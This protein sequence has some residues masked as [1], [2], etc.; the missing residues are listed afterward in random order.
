MPN[1]NAVVTSVIRLDPPLD[2]P[3][4]ELLR[5]ESGLSVELEGD[6]RVRLDPNDPRSAGFAQV[7]DGLSKQGLP[8]YIEVDP[9]TS[10]ITLLLIPHVARVYGISP[11]GDDV[12]SVE[13]ELSH[14]RHTLPGSSPDFDELEGQL[15]EALSTGDPVILTETDDHEIIDIREYRPGPDGPR[16]PFPKPE[17]IPEPS[18]PLRLIRRIWRIIL[19]PWWCFRCMSMTRAQQI[20]DAMNA[21]SCDPL[22]VPAPCIPFMYPDDG[23]WGRAHE[24]ARLMINMGENPKK[25]WIQGG[26]QVSTRNKPNCVVNWGWHVAPTLC[27]RGPGFFQNQDMV[28][29]PSLFTTPVSKATW[30]G[31]QGDPSATLTDSA[32]SIFY[33]WGNQ[34]DPTYTQTNT[35]LANYRLQLLNRSIQHGPPPYANCP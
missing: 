29:D 1:P 4:D 30:K 24:M 33:L 17:P 6:R 11:L 20:F 9:D 14:G 16:P 13:L 23:C 7:L 15:R 28:I 8:V 19:W 34:T 12:L 27:V 22:T 31:V 32:A 21:T 25:V 5:S 10:F 35:V 3:P 26:L 18:G 2:G